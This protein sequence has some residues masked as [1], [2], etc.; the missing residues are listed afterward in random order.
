MEGPF[1]HQKTQCFFWMW[2][3]ITTQT[4]RNIN[5]TELYPMWNVH[6][7]I[8]KRPDLVVLGLGISFAP[9][10]IQFGGKNN[11]TLKAS[12]STL[13]RDDEWTA[14]QLLFCVWRELNVCLWFRGWQIQELTRKSRVFVGYKN[15]YS[16]ECAIKCLWQLIYVPLIFVFDWR[17]EEKIL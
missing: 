1:I 7:F 12:W 3:K 15:I 13:F 2:G 14:R 5:K 8:R 10:T 4:P 17:L 9:L 6:S 16:P 11:R